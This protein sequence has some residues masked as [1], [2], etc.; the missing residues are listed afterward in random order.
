MTGPV[1]TFHKHPVGANC[2]NYWNFNVVRTGFFFFFWVSFVKEGEETANR[3]REIFSPSLCL[4]KGSHYLNNLPIPL[5]R[6]TR[7]RPD[8]PSEGLA[9]R[10][11]K[12][13]PPASALHIF[14]ER[15]ANFR[16]FNAFRKNKDNSSMQPV[17]CVRE[18]PLKVDSSTGAGLGA[19][20]MRRAYLLRVPLR[21]PGTISCRMKRVRSRM[22]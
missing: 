2:W 11:S 20:R 21:S 16:S 5:A 14:H 1:N 13:P 12:R 6:G 9:H 4:K 7:G 17:L 15:G 3:R 10:N 8:C 19:S 22:S 18:L